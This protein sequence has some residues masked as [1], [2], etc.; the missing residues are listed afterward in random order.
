MHRLLVLVLLTGCGDDAAATDGGTT[1]R[2]SGGGGV[3]SGS[4]PGE[5][6]GSFDAGTSA[7]TTLGVSMGPFNTE[8]GVER[9]LC[10][11]FDLGNTTVAAV[12][13]IRTHLTPGSH[14]MIVYAL[15]DAADPTIRPCGAFQ[16]GE[17]DA[18]FIAEKP[19]A[20]LVY[21]PGTGLTIAA[22]QTIGLELHFINYF[23][24]VPE[25]ISGMVELDLVEPSPEMREVQFLFTGDLALSI[26]PRMTTTV[27][28]F[29][30]IGEGPRV[31]ALTSHTHQLGTLAT[32]HRGT[33]ISDTGELLHESRN[34]AEP[35]LDT[36]DPALTFAPGEGLVLTCEFTNTTDRHVTFGTGFDDEM[37]F[38][39]AHYY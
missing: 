18:I 13:A 4:T 8:P 27:R 29:H 6:A 23:S 34:W 39:W 32:L 5:D 33:S 15:D 37:C 36:Y 17:S 24:D 11:S 31:F 7:V 30:S 1:T 28:S 21:P 3:D 12:R 26:P 19:E 2:D 22:H 25:D 16:H 10:A 20:A 14:H 38:L 9:T 35:P